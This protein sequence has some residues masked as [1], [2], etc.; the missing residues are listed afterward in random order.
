MTDFSVENEPATVIEPPWKLRV[1]ALFVMTACLVA[2]AVSYVIGAYANLPQAAVAFMILWLLLGIVALG[3]LSRLSFAV[4]FLVSLLC[5]LVSWRIA[6]LQGVDLVIYGLLA[7][8]LVYLA[9]FCLVAWRNIKQEDPALKLGRM[10]WHLT[11]IRI[12]IGF[13][14]VPI[15]PRSSSPAP[16]RGMRTSRR[17]SGLV[18]PP[19]SSSSRSPA[20]ASWGLRSE[21]VL[22][23]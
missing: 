19:R 5:L 18:C 10:V 6:A 15:S 8:F 4:G 2:M 21:S 3:L 12:Y 20:S 7:A 14:L 1:A 9:M 11:L 22:A 17:S 23:C 16:G 13:D